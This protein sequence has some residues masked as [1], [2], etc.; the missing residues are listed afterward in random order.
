[1]IFYEFIVMQVNYGLVSIITPSYNCQNVISETIDSIINQT[2]TN[3][4]LLITDD[5]STD[6]TRD[7]VEQYVE[8]D[9]RIKLFKLPVNG[10]AGMARNNSIK[11]AKG[12][13]IAFCD[14]DDRWLP[15][16][17]EKQIELMQEKQCQAVYSS[18]FTCTDGGKVNGIVWARERETAFSI[19]CDDKMGNLTFMYDT[20]KIGKHLMPTI[21]KRQDWAHKMMIMNLCKEAY[22]VKEPLAV[23][24]HTA[25]SISRNKMKLAK[26]NIAGFQTLGWPYWKA[27]LFF[28]FFFMPSYIVKRFNQKRLNN[29]YIDYL[30][31]LEK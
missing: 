5:C 6:S 20:S 31:L 26:Y 27:L 9:P 11:E 17:L 29:T 28:L 19:K 21:R 1:M 23:Y 13:Y 15:S 22:G 8:K 24:R 12:R 18:Y 16:K 3:W 10:G 4:E 2:Y 7:V 30:Y 25:G 14:S